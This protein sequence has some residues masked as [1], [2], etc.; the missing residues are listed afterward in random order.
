MPDYV[1]IAKRVIP[2]PAE[3]RGNQKAIAAWIET[4]HKAAPVAKKE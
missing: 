1:V 2:V 4:Q 3:L